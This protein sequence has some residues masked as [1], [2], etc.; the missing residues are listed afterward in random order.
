MAAAD[1]VFIAHLAG[2]ALGGG[3]EIALACDLRYA[4]RRRA[5]SSARRRSTLGLLPGNG[6]TQRLTRLIGP[7]A[8]DGAAAHRPHVRRPTRR[9]RWGSCTRADRRRGRGSACGRAPRRRPAARDRGDQALRPRGRSAA[10]RRRP[11]ARGRAGRGRCSAPRTPT[12]GLAAFV[13]KRK[14]EFVGRMSTVR[15]PRSTATSTGT[16]AIRCPSR[17]RP[18][19]RSFAEVAGGTADDVDAAVARRARARSATWSRARLLQAR[20]R[21][22]ASA[23]RHVEAHVDELVP[24]LVAEQGKTLREARIE[25]TRRP[26]R[27]AHYVGMPKALRGAHVHGP[28]PRRRRPR[29]APAA[30]RRRRRSCRG[31]SRR[32]CCRNKL[33]PALAVPATRWSPSRPARRR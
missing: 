6:G 26:T 16:P 19:A 5:T 17:T 33:G 12:E 27:C 11:R 13:E 29:A 9:C 20:R 2:H 21:S 31:T 10:A 32:R 23:A 30:R 22:S 28:R 1:Q 3:L 4:A 15:R 18:T 8:G 7:V 24:L 25:V 14:P